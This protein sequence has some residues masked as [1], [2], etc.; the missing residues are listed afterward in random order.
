M[1]IFGIIAGAVLLSRWPAANG[2][3]HISAERDAAETV[4][5]N[6]LLLDVDRIAIAIVRAD[7]NGAR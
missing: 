5:G 1:L 7:V 3:R 2:V 4:G 6:G